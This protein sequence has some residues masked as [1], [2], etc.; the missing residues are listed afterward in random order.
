M[1]RWG[2]SFK[3]WS[4]G[5]LLYS[6]VSVGMTFNWIHL[7]STEL[8]FGSNFPLAHKV[9]V[10]ATQKAIRTQNTIS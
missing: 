10:E 1:A 7:R 4:F 5:L 8:C 9:F 2:I 3:G 6:K